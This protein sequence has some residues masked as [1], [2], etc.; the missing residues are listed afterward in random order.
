MGL[1][2]TAAALDQPRSSVHDQ[3]KAATQALRGMARDSERAAAA[4]VKRRQG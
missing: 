2:E 4:R 1:D 3:L